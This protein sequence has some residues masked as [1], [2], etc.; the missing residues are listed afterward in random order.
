MP[1]GK[2]P[3]AYPT[4]KALKIVHPAAGIVA[5]LTIAAFWLMTAVSELFGSAATVIAVKTAIPWALLLLIPAL[6]ATGGSGFVLSGGRK[7]GLVGAK[8]RRMPLIA[9][10]GVLILV[11]AALFL[12]FKARTGAFDTAFYAVQALELL[13]GAANLALLALNMRD[14]L[15]MTGRL[16]R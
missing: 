4:A 10:N 13:A 9:G 8:M 6:I 1:D 15:R 11:P 7:A 16:R 12:A 2:S 5:M 14:G 3:R